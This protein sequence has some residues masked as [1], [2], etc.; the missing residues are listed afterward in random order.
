[1]KFIVTMKDPDGVTYAVNTAKGTP[2]AGPAVERAIRKWFEYEEYLEVEVDTE[3]GTCTVLKPN[4]RA[5]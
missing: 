5:R 4:R 3:A 2:G 1:M